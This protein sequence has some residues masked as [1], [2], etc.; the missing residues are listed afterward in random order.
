MARDAGR[1]LKEK[2]IKEIGQQ[3]EDRARQIRRQDPS[4]DPREVQI[5]AAQ[6][7]E[8][9]LKL[10]AIIEKRN[11]LLNQRKRIE[12]DA[13]LE[14]V[15]S[16]RPA[17]G[18]Q[19]ILTGVQRSRSGARRS[20]GLEQN[21]LQGKY[22]GGLVADI[23]R[24][25]HFKLFASGAADYDIARALWR[26]DD[27][28]P[29]LKGL[30]PEAV[31]IAR[32]VRKWQEVSRADANRE[33]AWIGKEKGYITRQSHDLHRIRKAGYQTWRDA[34]L[35]RLD[36]DR[37][38]IP[39]GDIEAYLGKVYEGLASGVHLKA[40]TR[41]K[42]GGFKGPANL[43]RKASQERVLHFKSADDWMAYNQQFGSGSLREAVMGGL[44]HSAQSTG[45]MRVLGTNP[46]SMLDVLGRKIQE[47]ITDPGKLQ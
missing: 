19:A 15:W 2:E 20:V 18:L 37:M 44:R 4:L 43:A 10:A 47:R 13:Y 33:G 38:D 8:Q 6:K 45:L 46:E 17:D 27:E 21:A 41:P 28:T 7:L 25:G 35:P 34:I 30:M 14:N 22:L 9:D 5:R 12:L 23:E 1:K 42:L 32:A 36:L 24:A 31:E 3:L 26:L 16:D 29:D 39:G 11:A 40:S